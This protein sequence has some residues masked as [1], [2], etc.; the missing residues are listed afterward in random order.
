[1]QWRERLLLIMADLNKIMID[2]QRKSSD[3]EN[4]IKELF[5]KYEILYRE[6]NKIF[7]RERIAVG[8]MEGLESFYRLIQVI[9]RNR[10]VIGSLLRGVNNLRSISDFKFVEEEISQKTE[11]KPVKRKKKSVKAELIETE[12]VEIMPE[13][14]EEVS[15]ELEND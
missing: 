15:E 4:S 14:F 11:K 5:T 7:H 8:S 6:G 2:I 1:M 12:P 3:I 13:Y 9:R 10:D